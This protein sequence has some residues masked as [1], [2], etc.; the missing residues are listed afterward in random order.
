MIKQHP[1]TR[2]SMLKLG[3]S[4]AA[5][6]VGGALV[7]PALG[8]SVDRA[9]TLVLDSTLERISAPENYNPFLPSANLQGGLQQVGFESLFYLNLE[10]GQLE[11]WQAESFEFNDTYD[12]VIITLR[13]GVMW[14][15]G[16]PFTADD[17]VFTM[18][19]LKDNSAALGVWGGHASTWIKAVE[20]L[21]VRTVK[22]TLTETNPSFV[23]NTFGARVFRV[24]QIVPKHIWENQDPGTF[25]NYDLEKGWPVSTSPYQLVAASNQETNWVLRENWWGAATGFRPLPE[26]KRVIFTTVGTEERRVAM[27]IN[28]DLDF[29]YSIG[30]DSFET[31]SAANPEVTTWFSEMPYAYTDA[32][33]R[34]LV[35]NN[36]VAPFDDVRVRRAVS[37]AINRDILVD[38]AWEGMSRP[39]NW[40]T[41][42]YP[43]LQSYFDE[44]SDLFEAKPA[45]LYDPARTQA[46]ME[47]AGYTKD[48][49]G[50][51]Q[52]GAG[53]RITLDIIGRQ[54]EADAAKTTPVITELLRRAGFDAQFRLLDT[55]TYYDAVYLGQASIFVS[56]SSG[57]VADPYQSF[58]MY[59]S[60][61]AKPVGTP[62]TGS[63]SR[64]SNAEYDALVD[65]MGQMA[66]TDPRFK[67]L[68]RPALD[69][70]LDHMP[71]APLTDAALLVSYNNRYW[72]N[73]PNAENPYFQPC[74]WWASSLYT[75]AHLKR[76]GA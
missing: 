11:P 49:S 72:T 66:P 16:Q 58:E 76:A 73:W 46:L 13:S 47:E 42:S 19:M 9:D 15:D 36:A 23:V 39:I 20:A 35:F 45:N 34:V 8:Q 26:P 3:V 68:I 38:I 10:T 70:W 12:E 25:T 17:V 74:L 22:F 24:N 44:V 56:N 5:L 62:S 55:S 7:G 28:N 52:D 40:V 59:H 48:G 50:F 54:S 21:D 63:N 60:R 2:R 65:E 53:K 67:A 27:L 69:I 6:A 31:V 43:G 37:S 29:A 4:F 30:K 32:G 33:S 41:P 51:W 14:S 71:T 1:L 61:H 64:W 75:I 57:S 18:Q